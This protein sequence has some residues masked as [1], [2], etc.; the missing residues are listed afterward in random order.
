[1]RE[2]C[3]RDNVRAETEDSIADDGQGS[4]EPESRE[5]FEVGG[6]MGEETVKDAAKAAVRVGRGL[7]ENP[8]WSKTVIGSVGD[9][10]TA[11]EETEL[12]LPVEEDGGNSG[13]SNRS[14]VTFSIP[15]GT[16]EG[17]TG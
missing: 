12:A 14:E 9:T 8:S 1:M 13:K 17:S 11:E 2:G 15:K 4:V 10:S 3:G 7:A 5:E 16:E 6:E